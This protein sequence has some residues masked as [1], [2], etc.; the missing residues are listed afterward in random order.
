MAMKVRLDG[1][2]LQPNS[3]NITWTL[4]QA[5]DFTIEVPASLIDSANIRYKP[6]QVW[7]GDQLF[8]SGIVTDRP[9]LTLSKDSAIMASLR[10][11][12]ELGQL[13]LLYRAYGR[14]HYQNELLI[15]VIQDLL[16]KMTGGAW[17]LTDTSTMVDPSIRTTVDLRSKESL[18]AQL[19]EACKS[20]P[21]VHLRYGGFSGG[22]H[23]IEIGAFGQLTEHF[24]AN[25]NNLT[26]DYGGK[27]SFSIIEAYGGQSGGRVITL[28]DALSNPET[29]SDP[30]YARFPIVFDP[31]TNTYYV[32][33]TH[34]QSPGQVTRQFTASK[35]QNDDFPSA[36]QL[37][38]AGIALWRKAVRELMNYGEYAVYTGDVIL[39]RIPKVGDK[40]RL[41]AWV[42]EPVYD[43][44]TLTERPVE[45][46][47]VDDILKIS[48]VAY[49]LNQ[50]ESNSQELGNETVYVFNVEVTTNDEAEIVDDD[51][52]L[53]ERLQD[54]NTMDNLV[55]VIGHSQ[56]I[57]A[58]LT[59]GPGDAADCDF[60][61]PNTGK[62]YTIASP[63]PPTGMSNVQVSYAVSPANAR[64]RVVS[65][66]STVGQPLV[67]CVAPPVG[68]W[69]PASLITVV[70]TFFFSP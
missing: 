34:S 32:E 43:P 56:P 51:V 12:D 68:S 7:V 47:R 11:M 37:Q 62:L 46:F 15:A 64:S 57:P 4:D 55:N 36:P 9:S 13:A 22:V 42:S 28:A 3:V 41:R 40:A 17:V 23:T 6:V 29:T 39:P 45:T 33:D 67:L 38:E 14:A 53:T 20:V 50:H 66:P 27:E 16:Q 10:C 49:D 48:R 19:A 1:R 8:V 18:F 25:I 31:I 63:T 5:A 70:A 35:T 52:Y 59:H 30:L 65:Y 69:P 24:E 60:D 61:G 58:T 21:Q 2:D 54:N 26:V 44:V